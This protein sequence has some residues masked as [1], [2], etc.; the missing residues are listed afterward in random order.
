MNVM[1]SRLLMYFML[2]IF[3][4]VSFY[5][6]SYGHCVTFISITV[7]CV[8][9]VK[10]HTCKSGFSS[11]PNKSQ[12]NEEAV[13]KDHQKKNEYG[14]N[15]MYMFVCIHCHTVTVLATIPDFFSTSKV[16]TDSPWS[17][18]GVFFF[19][20]MSLS[21]HVTCVEYHSLQTLFVLNI[22]PFQLSPHRTYWTVVLTTS[23]KFLSKWGQCHKRIFSLLS[24]APWQLKARG[25][26][27]VFVWN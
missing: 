24:L 13:Q 18:S 19:S 5:G 23:I 4:S 7:I 15:Y 2:F 14:K 26:N 27:N 9:L 8:C 6:P 21:I 3:L 22:T 11:R 1:R 20:Q 10:P 25:F 12:E 17:C 16:W